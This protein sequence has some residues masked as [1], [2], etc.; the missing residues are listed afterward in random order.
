MKNKMGK[1]TVINKYGFFGKLY[2]HTI[3]NLAEKI[4]TLTE[5]IKQKRFVN[6]YNWAMEE[7]EKG[8]WELVDT[9]TNGA[10]GINAFYEG[11]IHA[12]RVF[13][14]DDVIDS[15]IGVRK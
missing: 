14:T 8:N 12:M 3:N 4:E 7:L 15:K 11:A 9:S 13:Y 10:F 6:G 5:T 1:N 2:I